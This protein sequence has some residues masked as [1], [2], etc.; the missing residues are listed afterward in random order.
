MYVEMKLLSNELCQFASAG[1]LTGN[2]L[3]LEKREHLCVELVTPTRP[4]LLRHQSRNAGLVE[5]RPSLIVS[6]P[7]EAVL[8]G[9][10]RH[11]RTLYPNAAQ[12]LVLDLD[13]IAGVEELALVYSAQRN[14]PGAAQW[15]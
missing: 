7:R 13:E 12:H 3:T 10:V 5:A 14:S 2:K 6:R 4:P 1:W 15:N 8:F 11:R 9:D